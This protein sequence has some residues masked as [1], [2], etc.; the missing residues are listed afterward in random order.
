VPLAPVTQS[1]DLLVLRSA[2]LG[3]KD[4]TL[5]TESGR[6]QPVGAQVNHSAAPLTARE[7]LLDLDGH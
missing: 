7:L 2:D 3:A 4:D 6:F 1:V 5:T